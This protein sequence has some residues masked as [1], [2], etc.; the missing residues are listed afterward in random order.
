MWIVIYLTD[1]SQNNSPL[2][3]LPNTQAF[4]HGSVETSTDTLVPVVETVHTAH[5]SIDS[6]NSV[7]SNK[8]FAKESN[9][10]CGQINHSSTPDL[11]IKSI[12]RFSDTKCIAPEVHSSFNNN[13]NNNNN[14]KSKYWP[15]NNVNGT[16]SIDESIIMQLENQRMDLTSEYV[17]TT[18]N[19]TTND[20]NGLSLYRRR[21]NS[22]NSR[23]PAVEVINQNGLSNKTNNER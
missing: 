1:T 4:W 22:S 13:S 8:I 18:Q 2:N 12:Y 23:Q 11:P 10:Y 21:R 17:A 9:T 3:S 5:D 7:S 19:T 14:S 6:T 16:N 15:T 20:V